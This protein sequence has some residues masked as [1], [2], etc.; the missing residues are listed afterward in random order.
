[1]GATNNLNK[2]DLLAIL[3]ALL[4]ASDDDGDSLFYG[5]HREPI[6][7]TVVIEQCR[8]CK[9]V[10]GHQPECVVGTAERALRDGQSVKS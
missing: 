2:E 1:M 4:L 6:S 3:Q 5:Q 10:D 9:E 8:V 7:N